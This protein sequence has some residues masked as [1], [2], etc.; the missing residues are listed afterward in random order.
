MSTDVLEFLGTI[1]IA[2]APGIVPCEKFVQGQT[3]DKV[4]IRSVGVDFEKKFI[5]GKPKTEGIPELVRLRVHKVTEAAYEWTVR[6]ALGTPFAITIDHYWWLAR[7]MALIN[8]NFKTRG[9]FTSYMIDDA[10][11]PW[12]VDTIWPHFG[13]GGLMSSTKRI[14]APH[15]KYA[16]VFTGE[17]ILITR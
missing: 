11:I 9:E 7:N 1:E 8:E 12:I 10:G 2:T 4:K 16:E 5:S 15:A 17:T 14:M 3:I 6:D 13:S